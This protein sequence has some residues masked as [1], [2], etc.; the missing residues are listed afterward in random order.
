MAVGLGAGSIAAPGA[1]PAA[2]GLARPRFQCALG[3]SE[4]ALTRLTW[5]VPRP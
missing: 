3:T 2:L 4:P 1:S 5:P